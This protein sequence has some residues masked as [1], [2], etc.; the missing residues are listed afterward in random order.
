MYSI[1]SFKYCY[2]PR[3]LSVFHGLFCPGLVGDGVTI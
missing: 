3:Y 2:L 1:V